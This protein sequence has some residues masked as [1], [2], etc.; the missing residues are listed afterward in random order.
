M[1]KEDFLSMDLE[2]ISIYRQTVIDAQYVGVCNHCGRPIVNIAN[3]KDRNT[4]N[5]YEIGLD[6]KKTLMD[7]KIID[8]LANDNLFG[9]Q[10]VKDFKA[11][12]NDAIKFFLALGNP[13]KYQVE[14][15]TRDNEIVITD[16]ELDNGFGSLGKIINFFPVRYLINKCKVKEEF[17]RDCVNQ[18]RI[19]LR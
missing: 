11:Q 3:V 2:L 9:K 16:L 10:K 18:K 15:D 7:K 14:F 5:E 12:T 19:S 1:K 17:I 13:Q 6:C 4:N 8:E